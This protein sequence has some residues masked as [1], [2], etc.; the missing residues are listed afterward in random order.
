M[1]TIDNTNVEAKQ[2]EGGSDSF[3]QLLVMHT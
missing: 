2:L 3:A 1:S